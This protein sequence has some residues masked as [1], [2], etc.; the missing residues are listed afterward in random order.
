MTKAEAKFQQ[1]L[2]TMGCIVCRLFLGVRSPANIHHI[3]S[4]S[5][6]KGEMFALP[7]CRYHHQGGCNNPTYVSRHPFKKAFEAR[8][9]SELVLLEKCKELIAK[10]IL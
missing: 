10:G 6:R 8:Y 3:L 7:L 1:D 2:R 9:G 5:R 4:G